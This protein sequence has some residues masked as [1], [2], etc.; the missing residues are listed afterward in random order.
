MSEPYTY[1][2]TGTE[3]CGE[4][5]QKA[6]KNPIS[7][8]IAH[9]PQNEHDANALAVFVWHKGFFSKKRTRIGYI[10]K[11]ANA[12]LLQAMKNNEMEIVG[13]EPFRGQNN[14]VNVMLHIEFAYT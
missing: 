13:A 14:L 2:V 12:G 6:L 8:E 1:F 10:R 7:F 5:A 9:D 3:F 11:S 4:A